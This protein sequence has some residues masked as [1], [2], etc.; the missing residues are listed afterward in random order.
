VRAV[1]STATGCANPWRFSF[2]RRTGDLA[3][4]DV[5]QDQVEEIDFTRRG[6]ARGANFGWRPWEGRRRNFREPA[7]GAVFPVITHTQASGFCSITGGYVV[8]DPGLPSLAGRYLYADFCDSR[9]R[10]VRLRRGSAPQGAPLAL[11]KLEQVVSF[12]EDARGRVYVVSHTGAVYRL[13]A[14]R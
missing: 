5:G 8:R 10:A 13:A 4:A 14:A 7:P 12:G 1:R 2:D 9:I 6:R 11:P 3:I